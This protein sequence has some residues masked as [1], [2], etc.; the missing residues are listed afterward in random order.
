MVRYVGTV[1]ELYCAFVLKVV[2]RGPKL[3]HEHREV[4]FP[5]KVDRKDMKIFFPPANLMQATLHYRAVSG[6]F[7]PLSPALAWE[8]FPTDVPCSHAVGLYWHYYYWN[9]STWTDFQP[10]VMC[11]RFSSNFLSSR[12]FHESDPRLLNG[13]IQ[14]SVRPPKSHLGEKNIYPSILMRWMRVS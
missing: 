4:S 3:I 2:C 6:T 14:C 10:G 11:L 7:P 5:F 12:P 8:A 1:L 13:L 9:A